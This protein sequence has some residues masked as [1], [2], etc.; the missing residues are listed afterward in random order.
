MNNKTNMQYFNKFFSDLPFFQLL[1]KTNADKDE[2]LYIYLKD[3]SN[4]VF[5]EE[6]NKWFGIAYKYRVEDYYKKCLVGRVNFTLLWSTLNELMVAYFLE[7]MLNFKFKLP[8]P[9]AGTGKR[10]EWL[11]QKENLEIFIEVKSPW[12][13]RRMG[14]YFYRHSDKLKDKVIE[15][16]EHKPLKR[17]PFIVFITDALN[18]SP[19]FHNR[20]LKE[21]L[22]G[23]VKICLE[24]YNKGSFKSTKQVIIENGLF[25]KNKR[26]GLSAICV[27]K[28][29]V[30]P[31]AVKVIENQVTIIDKHSYHF[32]IYHNPLCYSECK[33]NKDWFRHYRQYFSHI[34]ELKP[35]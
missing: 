33:L 4:N 1:E 9:S 27:L 13:K 30:F 7:T 26:N 34:H 21:A 2:R 28:L 24:G 8:Q 19:A 10:G 6:I 22:Y 11:Y 20:E 23:E 35:F 12:E 16:H 25:Q 5:Q 31:D 18:I 3:K 29:N 14:T 15:G 17:I 32:S